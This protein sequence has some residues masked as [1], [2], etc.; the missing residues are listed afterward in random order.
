MTELHQGRWSRAALLLLALSLAAASYARAALGPLQ[1]AIKQ[2]LALSDNFMALL[3]GP[4]LAWPMVVGGIPVGMLVDRYSRKR[5]MLLLMSLTFVWTALAAGVEHPWLL[6]ALRCFA[7]MCVFATFPVAISLLADVCPPARRGRATMLLTIG[8]FTGAAGVFALGGWLLQETGS[9]RESLLLLAIPILLATI[10]LLWLREPARSGIHDLSAPLS[11]AFADIW[12]FRAQFVPLIVGVVIVEIALGAV[13]VWSAPVFSRNFALAPAQIGSI[14]G[15]VMF[16]S[17]IG[18]AI[19]GGMAADRAQRKGGVSASLA[20]LKSLALA[21]VPTGLYSIVPNVVASAVLL[22]LF[23]A[24]VGAI[25]VM[26]TALITI[27]L[28]GRVHGLAAAILSIAGAVLGIGLAPVTVSLTSTWLGG[29]SHIGQAISIVCVVTS[30]VAVV[31]F[32]AA[33]RVAVTTR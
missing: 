9:W 21:S 15:G 12:G 2:A 4:A 24:I 3:Q 31:V 23:V 19:L 8:Q 10:A 29:E 1:E 25:C 7:G 20:T 33:K 32:A 14:L 6:F 22:T 28:P 13:L 27:V 17:G 5:L 26:G 16:V 11:S 18:G 30:L